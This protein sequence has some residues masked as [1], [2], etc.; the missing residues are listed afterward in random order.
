MTCHTIKQLD[1]IWCE[2]S[3]ETGEVIKPLLSFTAV[4]YKQGY[5]RKERIEYQKSLLTKGK[6]CFYMLSG[7]LERV[8]TH[9]GKENVTY[10]MGEGFPRYKYSTPV[11]KGITLREDQLQLINS[12][13]AVG[14]GIIQAPT[15][16]G[17]TLLGIS[18]YSCYKDISLLWLC[19]T[20]D[21]MHQTAKEFTKQG[22]KVGLI[23]DSYCDVDKLVTIATRQSFIQYVEDL[24]TNYDMV[25]VDETHHVSTLKSDYYEIL[26]GVLAPLRFGLTA[27]LPDKEESKLVCEGLIGPVCAALSINEGNQLGIIAKPRIKF[28]KVPKNYAVAELRRY[29]D[30]YSQGVVHN[31]IK[32]RK[33][34]ETAKRHVDQ[35]DSVLIIVNQIEHGN[36]LMQMSREIR[37]PADFVQGITESDIRTQIKNDLNS[38]KIKCVI[39]T[40][41]FNEGINIPE[42][43]VIIN[44]VGGKSEIRTLQIL[45]RGLRKTKDKSELIM[46]DVFDPSHKYL[47]EHFGERLCVY[48]DADWI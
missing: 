3:K 15:G 39:A 25:I 30:V 36:N 14:R 9:L 21:L 18:I 22:F 26:T 28:I 32:N 48:S 45:G 42:L 20:K 4:Y 16:S 24:G 19:H 10:V 1:P 2:V 46:Y 27:T 37:V 23:G 11:L 12:A 17:K 44:A 41:I 31:S 6:N 43:N 40:A 29:A 38:K 35:G 33:I 47:L 13:N 5:Y 8:I 7:H 34:M